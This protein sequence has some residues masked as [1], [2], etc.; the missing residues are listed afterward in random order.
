VLILKQNFVQKFFFGK[1]GKSN[2]IN[3]AQEVK[4][5]VFCQ[6]VLPKISNLENGEDNDETLI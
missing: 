1:G 2:R 5:I 3:N 4:R 6:M